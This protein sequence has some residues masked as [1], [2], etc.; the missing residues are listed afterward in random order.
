M[1][2]LLRVLYRFGLKL[3]RSVSFIKKKKKISVG[4]HGIQHCLVHLFFNI[5]EKLLIAIYIAMQDIIR[6]ADSQK[7]IAWKSASTKT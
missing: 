7:Y 3:L 4:E 5:S 1:S 2:S 6:G